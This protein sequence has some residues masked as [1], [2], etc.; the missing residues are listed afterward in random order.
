MNYKKT[1]PSLSP[2]NMQS[3][4]CVVG[5]GAIGKASAL[6]LAQAGY[7]V[8]LLSPVESAAHASRWKTSGEWD[9]RVYA[10]NHAARALLLS[11]KVWDAMDQ[12]RIAPIEFMDIKGDGQQ[13]AGHLSFDA[14]GAHV[15]ALGWIIEDGNLN[16]A[17]DA[18]LQFTP[19][20]RIVPATAAGMQVDAASVRIQ[21]HSGEK[22]TA[23]LVLGA[24]GAHSWVRA[25]ADIG[26]DYRSYD[27]R[28]IVANFSCDKPHHGVASQWFLGDEGIVALLPLPE[29]RVSL[30]WS[31]PVKL[32][33][34]LLSETAEQ[35][36]SRL[37][38]LP[39]LSLG[40]LHP[41]PP[42]K[43]RGFP[44]RLMRAHS[45]T[46]QRVVLV[47]D[48]AHVCHPLA[49]QGMNLGFADVVDLLAALGR[50]EA[51]AD[52]G[53]ARVLE[54]YARGRKEEVLLMQLATDGLERLF[55]SDLAP[56]RLARNAGMNMLN[57]LPFLKRRL[58]R[59][60]LGK[61]HSVFS[62]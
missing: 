46:A 37:N 44:L 58:I 3:Q 8:I 47:G 53:D 56:L 52:C 28:A 9:S 27:Q 12:E 32:A 7:D 30:V 38:K 51:D 61:S 20:V 11:L 60:A 43:L 40:N 16:H 6:A 33:E 39:H 54:R 25:Q 24:D 17:L 15:G 59:H 34:T 21:L 45:F 50:A 22:L 1:D 42:A 5:N 57:R 2:M 29:S 10:L 31:A 23:S 55:T 36:A 49:G 41:L 13:N 48:A 35:L 26:L 19:G 62:Q 4:V 14:Y 18:A